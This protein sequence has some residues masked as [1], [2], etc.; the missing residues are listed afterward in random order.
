MSRQIGKKTFLVTGATGTISSEVVLALLQKGCGVVCLVRGKEPRQHL[1]KVIGDKVAYCE[2]LHGDIRE[3]LCG[4]S[5]DD[6]TRWKGSINAFLHGA[7]E[8][9]F[10]GTDTFETNVEGTRH[11]LELAKALGIE[12]FHAQ[13]TVYIAGDADQLLETD[14][15]VGQTPRNE[16]ERSKIEAERLVRGSGMPF[17]IHRIG[18]VVGDS[19]RGNISRF[20][21]YYGFFRG[22][23][24]LRQ[25]L[26]KQWAESSDI[27]QGAGISFD[28]EDVLHLPVVI[29]C[30]P[31][32]RLNLVPIDWVVDMMVNVVLHRATDRTYHLAHPNPPL[33]I[34]IIRWSLAFLKI[35][36]VIV[37]E[38]TQSKDGESF[39]G[40]LQS[41]LDHG[42]REFSAYVHHE[43]GFG[44]NEHLLELFGG[45]Y[46]EP[47]EVTESFIQTLLAQ[48][49]RVNF[50]SK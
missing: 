50:G 2:I 49:I 7:A 23:C 33:V 30:S 45:A 3:P 12:E 1:Q 35:Q 14:F 24:A 26:E 17:S 46:Y 4:V 36:D 6:V 19:E 39:L 25:M 16:Y 43:A 9:K 34:D 28:M 22:V 38:H 47:R 10:N 42:L 13:S 21:G 5:S 40:R 32:S 48:A 41:M 15:E 8:I 44:R 27:L 37:G 18:I 11:A 29:S 31:S 20:T